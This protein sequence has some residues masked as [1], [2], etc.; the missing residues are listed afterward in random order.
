M[1]LLAADLVISRAGAS[2]L[3][4]FSA[5]GL[6]AILVPYP[7]A[8]PNQTVNADY[9]VQHQAAVMI[10]DADLQDKLKTTVIDLL[11]DTKKLQTLRQAS[12]ELARPEAATRLA[13]AILEV[14]NHG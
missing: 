8:G 4:E 11:T 12:R 13:Q 7:Y 10:K 14:R 3:G 1:A 6:P 9:L 5:V 2:T